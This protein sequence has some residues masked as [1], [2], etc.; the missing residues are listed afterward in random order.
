MSTD[1]NIPD[2]PTKLD[3]TEEKM[4]STTSKEWV[5]VY[6]AVFVFIVI[7]ALTAYH[8]THG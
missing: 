8:L 1:P 2:D 7:V 5:F 3:P 6:V 4:R